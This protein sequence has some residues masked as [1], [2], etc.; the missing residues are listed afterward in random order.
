MDEF[1]TDS[2]RFMAHFLKLWANDYGRLEGEI[3]GG[4]VT[5]N[6]TTLFVTSN[7]SMEQVCNQME[8]EAV[9]ALQRRFT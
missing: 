6:F 7:Y 2:M 5:L 8:D 9:K 3:K 4:K 1:E